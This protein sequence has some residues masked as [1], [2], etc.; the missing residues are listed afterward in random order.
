MNAPSSPPP[1]PDTGNAVRSANAIRE[2]VLAEVRKAVV[3]QDEPLELMLCGLVAGG[4]I[5]L[6]GVP[7]VAKTLMAKALSRSVGAD[8]KRI[9]FTPDLMPADILGTSVFDLKSQAFVLARGP[10]FTDL[11]L[12]D[13]INRAPAKTQSALLEAMQERAVS[14]EGKNLQLSPMFTVF[15]TQ[16]PV[17]SEG[18]YPLPEA[19]LDRFLLK[20]DV[21]YPAPEEEDAILESVH[22]GFDAGDLAR[23]GVSAAVTKDDLLQARVALNTVNVE[24]PVLAYIRKLV[25]ATRSSP[26][27]RLGAGPRAGVHLLLASKALAALRGRDFVTPDDVRFLVGPV[28]RHRLLLSPDAELDGATAADVLR[29]VVQG[30]EVPR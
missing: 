28:L 19:Q 1:F 26:N 20:I 14:L 17:E 21:G 22:R 13:E 30:V 15:A 25:A 23:A 7:G 11:L 9:Q 4:H 8:F 10:I 18:T 6:E 29:E 5:L 27:I 12:A 24:P 3:G 2:G 16:N